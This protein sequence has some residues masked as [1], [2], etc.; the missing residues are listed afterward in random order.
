VFSVNERTPLATVPLKDSRFHELLDSSLL[1]AKLIHHS[2]MK[3]KSSV[4]KSFFI[5]TKKQR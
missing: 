1:L 5:D 4:V 3:E 2:M